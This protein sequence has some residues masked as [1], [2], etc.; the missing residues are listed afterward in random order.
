MARSV[1]RVDFA[2]YAGAM[3]EP[4]LFMVDNAK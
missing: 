2:R 3:R 4:M 1:I